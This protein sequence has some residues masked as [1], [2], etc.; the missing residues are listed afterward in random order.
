L[1]SRDELR[2]LG[3]KAWYEDHVGFWGTMIRLDMFVKFGLFNDD[4]KVVCQ[5]SD[6]CHRIGKYGWKTKVIESHIIG[7]TGR[8]HVDIKD[9]K[10]VQVGHDADQSLI[11]AIWPEKFQ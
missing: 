3:D 11:R 8:T 4:F 10:E 6:F 1:K 5:D 7:H 2:L 9:P